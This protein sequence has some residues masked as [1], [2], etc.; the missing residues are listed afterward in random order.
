[1]SD[2]PTNAEA[3]T[4]RLAK[5]VDLDAMWEIEHTVFVSDAWSREMMREE[6]AAD[7]RHYLVVTDARGTILGY[8]GLMIVGT[9]A[10]VQTIAT[11]AEIRGRGEGRRLMNAL[12]A[13]ATSRGV[14]AV[15]L[16]VRADNPVARA[17]YASLGFDEI[18]IRPAYYQP[19]S[20]DAV[21]MKLDI[22][23]RA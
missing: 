14:H 9:E 4:L 6:L 1:M 5:A 12:I 2:A 11:T 17:L 21:V 20:I 19:G 18:G 22:K 8:A 23:D 7:H 10:D 13:E 15:F 16:E 3:L